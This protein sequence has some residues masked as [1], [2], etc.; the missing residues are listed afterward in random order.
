L[1]SG[2]QQLLSHSIILDDFKEPKSPHLLTEVLDGQ[3]VDERGNCP[4]DLPTPAGQEK[5]HLGMLIE[6]VLLRVQIIEALG[7]QRWDPVGITFVDTPWEL[8]KSQ[9]VTLSGDLSDAD[10]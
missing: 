2:V 4:H 3:V 7:N 5:G 9:Q 8:D 10:G 6:G 1:A